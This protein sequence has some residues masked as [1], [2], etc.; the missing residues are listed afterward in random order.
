MLTQAIL[1]VKFLQRIA[2]LLSEDWFC[3]IFASAKI[4]MPVP[5]ARRRAW[6]LRDWA[7]VPPTLKASFAVHRSTRATLRV[8]LGRSAYPE[9]LRSSEGQLEVVE[10]ARLPL[11]FAS[12]V[13]TAG[14]A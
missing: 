8:T 5:G 4:V 10:Q 1:T 2:R 3:R 7:V 12:K 11:R 6:S 9:N 14:I 13:K